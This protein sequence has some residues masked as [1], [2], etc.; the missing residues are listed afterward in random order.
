RADR[1]RRMDARARAELA[2]RPVAAAFAVAS[3]DLVVSQP[4][5]RGHEYRILHTLPLERVD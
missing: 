2:G 5:P 3:I 4:T 1:R